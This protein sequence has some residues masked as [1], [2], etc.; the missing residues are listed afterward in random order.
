MY[1]YSVRTCIIR[2]YIVS[3]CICL[4]YFRLT[5]HVA[6][7]PVYFMSYVQCAEKIYLTGYMFLVKTKFAWLS[8]HTGQRHLCQITYQHKLTTN[9]QAQYIV[10]AFQP[11]SLY[12]GNRFNM[13]TEHLLNLILMA[14]YVKSPWA[15]FV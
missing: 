13:N 3:Y 7:R 5:G 1:V 8:A 9:F 15:I 14:L 11:A 4:K 10:H 2:S 12:L 6:K